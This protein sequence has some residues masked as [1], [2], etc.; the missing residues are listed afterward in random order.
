[1][2]VK[3]VF[4][5][6][7][8]FVYAKLQTPQTLTQHQRAVHFLATLTDPV[9]VSVQVLNEFTSALLKHQ[10]DETLIQEAVWAIAASSTVIPLTWTIVQRA[11]EIKQRYQFSYWDSLII[12]AALAA[13]C[14]VLYSEDLQ[15][16]QVIEHTLH[17]I[18]PLAVRS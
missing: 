4:V 12:G 15:H 17:I 6:T 3:R 16:Q 13:G 7:N 18:N 5:D 9:V 10:I 1:M 2:S 14:A 8:L 11:W